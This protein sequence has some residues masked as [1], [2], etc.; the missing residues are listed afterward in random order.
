[1]KNNIKQTCC[2]IF[3]VCLCHLASFGAS[4]KDTTSVTIRYIDAAPEDSISIL[5]VGKF[6]GSTE[7]PQYT[8]K[9]KIDSNGY[10]RFTIPLQD[11]IE[12]FQFMLFDK[13]N[14]GNQYEGSPFTPIAYI[15]K[16]DQMFIQIKKNKPDLNRNIIRPYK[17]FQYKY[18][19]KGSEKLFMAREIDSIKTKTGD[20]G[21]P[22]FDQ[23]FNY[24]DPTIQSARAAYKYLQANTKRLSA[25]AYAVMLTD[26]VYIQPDGRFWMI[27]NYFHETAD[28]LSK[29]VMDKLKASYN[30]GLHL[31]ANEFVVPESGLRKSYRYLQFIVGKLETDFLINDGKPSPSKVFQKLA[32][33]YT[34]E[35]RD[36]A[37]LFFLLNSFT[38]G[39]IAQK[40]Q[41]AKG[42]VSTDYCK[43]VLEQIEYRLSGN[44][45]YGFS[46]TDSNG[47]QVSLS[48]FKNKI[49]LVDFWFTGCGSCAQFYKDVL[50]KAVD[51]YQ[52]EPKV[53]FVS[54]CAD[55]S[56][57]KWKSSISSG[58]YASKNEVNLFTGGE[59]FEHAIL[60]R[61]HINDFPTF[62][63]IDQNGKVDAFQNME[64][65][66]N[67]DALKQNIRELI[68]K[69][70]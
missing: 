60:K 62:I 44:N 58:D 68:G 55:K 66:Y 57:A 38:D 39:N 33:D 25:L 7:N 29:G 27:R 65:R 69:V 11:S 51:E 14:R 23:A 64:Y 5:I 16:G 41:E 1:M 47:K 2:I 28:T 18:E 8:V 45:I 26:E 13:N 10:C 35:I 61:L 30:T 50:S 6:S 40:V 46:L 19:G 17:R 59:G 36:R 37:L 42:L 56:V 15:E 53:V 32:S 4:F 12:R 22:I 31:L 9:K 49:V 43:K 20:L 52:H 48:K 54:I 34:G 67:P 21:L 24:N 63:I 70:K 3:L